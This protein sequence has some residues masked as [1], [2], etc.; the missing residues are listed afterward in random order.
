MNTQE[1]AYINGFVKRASE[2]GFSDEQAME[3]CKQAISAEK[4]ESAKMS[5]ILSALFNTP[6][7]LY[8]GIKDYQNQEINPTYTKAKKF[9]PGD[10]RREYL[11]QNS[12]SG[13][14]MNN[15]FTNLLKGLGIGGITGLAAGGIA[16][17][18]NKG[19]LDNALA[20]GAIG[21]GI[22][23]PVGVMY[24]KYQGAKKYNE[25]LDRIASK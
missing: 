13:L 8:S 20:M 11:Y 14:T 17:A 24:N 18:A 22:G 6:G 1:Q 25:L 2:Y 5:P 3:L 16:A 21:A 23:G 4:L 15:T 10:K 12:A 7:D 9:E 19:N